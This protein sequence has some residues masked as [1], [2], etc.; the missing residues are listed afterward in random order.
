MNEQSEA[1]A[2][3]A[4]SNEIYVTVNNPNGLLIQ[5]TKSTIQ[6]ALEDSFSNQ[7]AQVKR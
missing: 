6:I 7:I 5:V 2:P 1:F 4:S 3:L